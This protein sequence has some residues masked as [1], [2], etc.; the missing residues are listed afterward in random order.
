MRASNF[1]YTLAS[2]NLAASPIESLVGR[3]PTDWLRVPWEIS[4]LSPYETHQ[5]I[6]RLTV[7]RCVSLR[8]RHRSEFNL[9]HNP[10]QRVWRLCLAQN[11]KNY[12][13]KFSSGGLSARLISPDGKTRKLASTVANPPLRDLTP[14][15]SNPSIAYRRTESDFR[16]ANALREQ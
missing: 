16:T 9:I 11:P 7:H 10:G 3:H 4:C 1:S 13:C 15:Y 12:S 6:L 2:S 14:V 5:Y 8:C